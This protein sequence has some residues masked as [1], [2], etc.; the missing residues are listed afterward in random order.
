MKQ[1]EIVMYQRVTK[2]KIEASRK[3]RKQMTPAE[4]AFW[5]MV[6]DKQFLGLKFRRQQI[7]RGFIVDFYCNEIGLVVEIDGPIHEEPDLLKND[8]EK[9]KIFQM[10]GLSLIRFRNE[11]VLLNKNEVRRKLEIL[12]GRI[13][14]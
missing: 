4:T 10:M 11:E 6:K 12:I 2:R 5:E 8:M 7:I 3:L 14:E 13:K 1:T 9:E